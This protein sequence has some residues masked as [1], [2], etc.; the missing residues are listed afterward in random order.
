M[1]IAD[2]IILSVALCAGPPRLLLLLVPLLTWSISEL[3]GLRLGVP[4][5]ALAA[6]AVAYASSR[7][8]A[9]PPSLAAGALL[10]AL[11][12]YHDI[13]EAAGAALVW[14]IVAALLHH[15]AERLESAE[16]PAWLQGSPARLLSAALLY[17]VA[18]PALIR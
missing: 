15:L 3:V 6:L 5:S 8:S 18:L 16:L 1:F 9:P 14:A 4:L 11:P 10:L 12:R 17:A 7:R 13:V 2:A